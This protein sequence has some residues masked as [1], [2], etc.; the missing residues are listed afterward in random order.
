MDGTGTVRMI[1]QQKWVKNGAVFVKNGAVFAQHGAFYSEIGA[2]VRK[3]R[4]RRNS[5]YVSR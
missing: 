2:G 3:V 5:V 1:F 4:N